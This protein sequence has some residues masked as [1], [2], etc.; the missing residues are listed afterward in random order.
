MKRD[1]LQ[2]LGTYSPKKH[3]VG[4]WLASEKLDGQRVF[5]D[6]GVT[7]GLLKKDIPWANTAKDGRY[8]DDQIATGLWTRLGNVIHAPAKWL[9]QLPPVVLDGELYNPNLPR[10]ELRSIIARLTPDETDWL[11]AVRLYTFGLIPLH[12][13]FM[14]GRIDQ[15]NF[16]KTIRQDE[17]LPFFSKLPN[18]TLIASP[19]T[20]AY[21][22]LNSLLEGQKMIHVVEQ[23]KLPF[24]EVEE[25][26]AEWIKPI[27]DKGGEG[28]V[29]QD[30]FNEW[31]PERSKGILKYK[32]YTDSEAVVIGYRSGKAGFTGKIGALIVKW[33]D[34]QFELSGMTYMQRELWSSRWADENPGQV[35][36]DSEDGRLIHRGDTVKFKYRNL[37]N[38]GVPQE[39][40][41]LEVR[42]ED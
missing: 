3:Y 9:D 30:P 15:P 7:R 1:F 41:F 4:G 20:F 39:A 10:Q 31:Q 17:C 22:R 21:D 35:M 6:G 28:M 12:R 8:K 33:G 23:R 25:T 2:Q 24:I 18:K 5:W 36:P 13:I 37:S 29:L 38:D 27:V 34:V 11:E 42:N 40:S 14:N 26:L 32:P 19:F 16:K